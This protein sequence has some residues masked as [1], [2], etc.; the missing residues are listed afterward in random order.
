M[1]KSITKVGRKNSIT[2][3]IEKKLESILKIGG[4][5]SEACAYAGIAERTYY[6]M[7]ER[8]A[9]FMQKMKAAK[10]YADIVAK[11]IVVDSLVKD[12]DLS[13]AKWWLEKRQFRNDAQVN[14]QGEKVLVMPSAV[15]EKYGKTNTQ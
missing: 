10:H 14:I 9:E 12:K 6:S 11:N 2:P 3:E 8:N 7:Q 4:T 1:G 15:Y 5:N 13:T